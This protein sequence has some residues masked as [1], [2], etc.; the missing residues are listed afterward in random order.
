MSWTEE[1]Y[2]IYEL[3]CSRE[4]DDTEPEMLPVSH[5]TANAQIEVTIDVNGEFRGARAVEKGEAVTV[6]PATEDSAVRTSGVCPMPYAD[7]LV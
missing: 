7:K 4:F 3:N 6:I 5:S 2:N 1:L